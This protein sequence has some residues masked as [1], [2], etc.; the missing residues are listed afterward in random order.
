MSLGGL[1]AMLSERLGRTPTRQAMVR[2]Q[3]ASGGNPFY[4][5][6]LA[7]SLAED[8]TRSDLP[9]PSSLAE[10]VHARVDG[11]HR[12][13]DHVLLAA[14]CIASPTTELV[15][16]AAGME[17]DR[18]VRVLDE[19]EDKGI[20]GIE[21]NRIRFTHP[22]LARGVYTRASP[23]RRRAMHGRLAEVI[24]EPEVHARHLAL[25]ATTADA[26][27]L[28]SLDAAARMARSRGA[29]AAAAELLD[30]AIRLGGDSPERRMQLANHQ[31]NSGNASRA[32]ALLED[33]I[34]G[35][36]P[37]VLRA[38]AKNQLAV[39]RLSDDSFLEAA[40]LLE[41]VLD[42]AE[43]DTP[44]R[45]QAL[46]SLAYARMNVLQLDAA[47]RAVEDAVHDAERIGDSHSLSQGLGMRVTLRF[48][49]GEGLDEQNMRRALELQEHRPG[50][51]MSFRPAVHNA[52]CLAW[53]GQ[54]DA[55]HDKMLS[56]RQGCIEHGEES[57][58]MFLAFHS[59]LIA[60]WRGDLVE[61]ALIGDDTME[62]SEQMGGDLPL[63]TALAIRGA[64]A[65][66]AGRADD[67]RR[68][69][70]A[71][72]EASQRCGSYTLAGLPLTTLG[73]IEV[74]VGNHE[75]ALNYVQP[76]LALVQAAPDATEVFAT[77]FVPDAAEAMARLGRISEAEALSDVM[78][79]NGRRLDRP[80]MLAIGARCRSLL[81]TAQGDSDG[82][83][84]AAERAH[85][86][87][88]RLQMPFE[89]ARTQLL[90]GQL[91][92]KKRKIE[93]ATATLREAL[94]AFER[95]DVP[96]WDERVRTE[97]GRTDITSGRGTLL[98]P[99]EQRVAELAATGMTNRE[100]AGRLFISP[101]TVEANLSRIY[102]KFGIQS[103]AELGGRMTVPN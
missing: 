72:L 96:L 4:A 7:R 81:L 5:L 45:V 73:F 92:R 6:E 51:P 36:G 30:M 47:V 99:S 77:S 23:A 48:M 31:F 19:A 28:N 20:V 27:T 88:D 43:A 68:D 83:L 49:R 2:I 75:A 58:L 3:E 38:E 32:R 9:L 56:L 8:P 80:W 103:R 53:S 21:G 85:S 37:G 102:R 93:L 25:A 60:I 13:A 46:L 100:V 26:R 94:T 84:L 11:V 52:L 1:H 54:L 97:L 10:L 79:R 15:A 89:R 57:E 65:A 35:L 101:K 66:Y 74:S 16:Q 40:A 90:L 17:I 59:A 41:S 50:I 24:D 33:T 18:A 76:L 70:H 44:L 78:E 39:V 64:L 63:F 42:E 95:I 87:H 55:A 22:L 34:A 86:E 61:A 82:A 91:Q 14:A 98:T 71:A 29:P 69:A 62:R 12:D 67:A